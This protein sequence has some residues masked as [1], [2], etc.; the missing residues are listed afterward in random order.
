MATCRQQLQRVCSVQFRAGERQRRRKSGAD[1]LRRRD[2]HAYD[3]V[4]RHSFDIDRTGDVLAMGSTTGSLWISEDQGD[5]WTTV[6]TFL[7]PIYCA[8]FA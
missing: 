7:P 1:N 8:R 4:Y 6:S 2:D 3:V 5:S